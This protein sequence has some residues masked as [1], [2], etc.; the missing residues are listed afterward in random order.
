MALLFR[1]L[2][3]MN[4]TYCISHEGQGK[5]Y[6]HVTSFHKTVLH[7]AKLMINKTNTMK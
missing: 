4:S 1:E 6:W 3:S 5:N 2:K 7:N